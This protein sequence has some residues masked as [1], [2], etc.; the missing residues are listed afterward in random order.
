VVKAVVEPSSSLPPPKATL[1]ILGR[2]TSLV[3]TKL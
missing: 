2:S 3:R 1:Q